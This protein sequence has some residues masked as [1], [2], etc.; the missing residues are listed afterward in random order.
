MTEDPDWHVVMIGVTMVGDKR[1]ASAF[2][3]ELLA[4]RLAGCAVLGTAAPS[5]CFDSSLVSLLVVKS[6]AGIFECTVTSTTEVQ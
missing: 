5:V 4:E 2:T 3:R 1:S 6:R